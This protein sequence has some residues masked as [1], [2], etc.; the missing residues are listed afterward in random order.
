LRARRERLA[1]RLI[2]VVVVVVVVELVVVVVTSLSIEREGVGQRLRLSF[3][4]FSQDEGGS[5][6]SEE[7]KLVHPR[8]CRC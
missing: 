5:Q 3:L 1:K 8:A 7:N 2:I 6:E 4:I